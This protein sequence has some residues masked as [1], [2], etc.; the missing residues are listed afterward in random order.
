MRN[1]VRSIHFLAALVSVVA[2]CS[3]VTTFDRS[4]IKKDNGTKDAGMDG[5]VVVTD[6]GSTDAA[7]RGDAGKPHDAGRDAAML[8]K[9]DA[10]HDAAVDDAGV[11]DGGVECHIATDCAGSDTEC[12]V[13]TCIANK[14]GVHKVG[15]GVV[16]LPAHQT[17]GDCKSIVCDGNGGTTTVNDNMDSASDGLACTD[18][19]C[20]NGTLQHPFTAARHACNENGGQLCDGAGACVPCL[21]ATDCGSDTECT[22]FACTNDACV[23][24][25]QPAGTVLANQTAGDCV[26]RQCDSSGAVVSVALPTD[27]PPND[28]NQCTDEVCQGQTPQHRPSAVGTA[29]NQ[30]NGTSCDGNGNCVTCNNATDCGT[31]TECRTFS[32]NSHVCGTTDL[33]SGSVLATQTAG[34]CVERQCGANATIVNVTAPTDIPATDNNQCTNEVCVGQTPTHAPT[35]AGVACNQNGGKVCD[36]SSAC[37]ACVAASDCGANTECTTYSCTNHTCGSITLSPGSAAATQTAGDCIQ[38]QCDASGAVV[39]ATDPT[40]V[41]ASDNNQCTDEVC[42]GQTPAHTP[43]ASGVA[44]SQNGGHFCNGSSSCV[45]CLLAST[46][47]GTDTFCQTRACDTNVCG[48]NY[49]AIG[50]ALPAA[51]QVTGDCKQV[52]CNGALGTTNANLDTDLPADDG[53]ECTKE[54]CSSGTPQHNPLPAGTHCASNTKVCSGATAV[55]G[56]CLVDSVCGGTDVCIFQTCVAPGALGTV[57]VTPTSSPAGATGVVTIIFTIQN[58]WPSNGALQILFP[59][60]F[61]ASAATVTSISL[62]GSS[63]SVMAASSL[64]LTLSRSGGSDTAASTSVS[65]VLDNIKNPPVS[66]T[67]GQYTVTTQTNAGNDIDTATAASSVLTPAALTETSLTPASLLASATG[68]ATVDF[69]TANPWPKDG[70]LTIVF[71]GGFDVSAVT[72]GAATGVD[73]TIAATTA[74]WTVTLTRDGTGTAV[75]SGTAVSITLGSVTNPAATGAT[76]T[77]AITTTTA[78]GTPIDTGSAPAVTIN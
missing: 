68:T 22:T 71:P 58:G 37:V 69:T 74:G 48:F 36:G 20:S 50:T 15:Q 18:D 57:S 38:R 52:E 45:E 6:A 78:P 59:T 25:K 14:C 10:G 72:V 28:G 7:A 44:C 40:D 32:C 65:V 3:L 39:N 11:D 21:I 1:T 76:G 29:C 34:D 23:P 62:A 66:G 56:G 35:S 47:S 13:R 42:Q 77:F 51:S 8:A 17:V 46:C 53:N 63:L 61:D 31:N 26:Q 19:I 43:T 30:T 73:K 2:G 5:A 67:T 54:A 27:V 64:G 55:C 33:P 16:L 4:K 12:H 24:S 70:T 41:P 75:A 49:T 9:H 60:G